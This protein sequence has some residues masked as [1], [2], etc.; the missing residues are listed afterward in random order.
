M[1]RSDGVKRVGWAVG[2]LFAGHETQRFGVK[3]DGQGD[4]FN[5]EPEL[6][7]GGTPREA[8]RQ[9]TPLVR[10]PLQQYSG[11]R[12]FLFDFGAINVN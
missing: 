7:E 3:R 2:V 9:I 1:G 11:N 4:W 10:T 5:V 6:I 12:T 8:R